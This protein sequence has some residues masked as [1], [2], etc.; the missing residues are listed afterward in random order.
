MLFRSLVG[1]KLVS[2]KPGDGG[3]DPGTHTPNTPADPGAEQPPSASG[4]GASPAGKSSPKGPGFLAPSVEAALDSYA[5]QNDK[6]QYGLTYEFL[7]QDTD[8]EGR[9]CYHLVSRAQDARG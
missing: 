3:S 4:K 9:I 6:S 7:Y 8:G 1:L 5:V 2:E